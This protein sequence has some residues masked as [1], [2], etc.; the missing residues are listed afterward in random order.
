VELIEGIPDAAARDAIVWLAATIEGE[1]GAPPLSDAALIHL[2]SSD[3]RHVVAA[4]SGAV[5]GYAQAHDMTAEVAAEQPAVD[6]L[7]DAVAVRGLLV[8][9]HGRRSRLVP[10][11]ARRGFVRVRELRQLR[12]P[13]AEL[14][15]LAPLPAGVTVRAFRPG[16]DEQ[17]WLAVNAAAFASHPEQ[18]ATTLSDLR[19]LMAQP[20]F[21]AGDLLLAERD[22]QVV[23][24]HWTKVHP[25]G[26]GEVYV[27]G[28]SPTGQGGG[29]GRALLDRGLAHLAERGCRTVQLYVDAD[30]AGAVRLYE[31]AGFALHDVDEQWRAG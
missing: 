9:S 6:P 24:F 25:A 13:L 18:G 21:R 4:P 14:S 16:Q 3:V 23:G 22:G 17:A 29:L 11:L 15:D 28:I 30:N 19:G 5:A 1:D 8:W 31:R 10:S 2:A 7:L 27:L 26:L 20:W 12:R